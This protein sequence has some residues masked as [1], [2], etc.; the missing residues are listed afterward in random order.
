[1]RKGVSP[2]AGKE[3]HEGLFKVLF[4]VD[5]E[6]E[7]AMAMGGGADWSEVDVSSVHDATF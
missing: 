1:M 7:R 6:V 4:S 5:T 3:K 2:G